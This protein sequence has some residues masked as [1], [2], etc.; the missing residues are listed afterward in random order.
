MR[1]SRIFDIEIMTG[2][3]KRKLSGGFSQKSRSKVIRSNSMNAVGGQLC[4]SQDDNKTASQGYTC[5]AGLDCPIDL[6]SV[7]SQGSTSQCTSHTTAGT[8]KGYTIKCKHCV[9]EINMNA[10]DSEISHLQCCICDCFYHGE[11]LSIPQTLMSQ[12]YIVIEVGGWS[13][14]PCRRSLR[15]KKPAEPC[16]PSNKP[17]TSSDN[18]ISSEISNIKNQLK[19]ITEFL[20]SN[21]FCAKNRSCDTCEYGH[22]T[23]VGQY[24]WIS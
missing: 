23:E 15:S 13:C 19:S 5:A 22:W 3:N 24:Q 12:L 21:F 18:N 4:L 14:S 9:E 8:S 10:E 7:G 2:R 6:D 11:C 16:V 1:N 17:A 20:T